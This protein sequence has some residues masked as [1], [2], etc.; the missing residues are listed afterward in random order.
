MAARHNHHAASRGAYARST[1]A[2]GPCTFSP[3][4]GNT[5]S[6]KLSPRPGSGRRKDRG[7][8]PSALTSVPARPSTQGMLFFFA[9]DDEVQI[10]SDG[11]AYDSV[12]VIYAP[13]GA[14]GQARRSAPPNLIPLRGCL[15]GDV[16][17]G[18]TWRL[19]EEAG[20]CCHAACAGRSKVIPS[21]A[22]GESPRHGGQRRA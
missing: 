9:R 11:I 1:C 20:P 4:P 6:R 22:K 16:H 5:G 10:W 21:D 13:R 2:S 7:E 17:G 14:A 19:P 8:K 3:S 12:R 15:A 18:P